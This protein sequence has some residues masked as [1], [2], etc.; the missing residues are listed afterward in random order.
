[1]IYLELRYQVPRLRR[2]G[3]WH[4]IHDMIEWCARGDIG[5]VWPKRSCVYIVWIAMYV[6]M[7]VWID[8]CQDIRN[9]KMTY[10]RITFC[11]VAIMA[12]MHSLCGGFECRL[13]RC[14]CV[15]RW[16]C[17]ALALLVQVNAMEYS[18]VQC[19]TMECNTMRCNGVEESRSA[20][21]LISLDWDRSWRTD[22]CRSGAEEGREE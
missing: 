10:D 19:N 12:M 2:R 8:G 1:M 4:Q 3:N 14:A 13:C 16:M 6:C 9:L 18:A 22:V 7:Y 20:T 11:D 17:L 21:G 15:C 5:G